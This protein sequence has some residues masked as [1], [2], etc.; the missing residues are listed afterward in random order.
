MGWG[1]ERVRAPPEPRAWVE[2]GRRI[3]VRARKVMRSGRRRG[4]GV[5]EFRIRM[6]FGRIGDSA[7]AGSILHVDLWI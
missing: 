4:G 5:R 1:R 6:G 2:G 3:R 7:R